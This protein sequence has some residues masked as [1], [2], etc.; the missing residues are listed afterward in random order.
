MKE[1][2]QMAWASWQGLPSFAWEV[3][4]RLHPQAQPMGEMLTGTV[5]RVSSMGRS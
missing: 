3:P 2:D 5:F 4:R 1:D